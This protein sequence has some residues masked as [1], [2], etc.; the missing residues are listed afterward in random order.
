MR[1]PAGFALGA[2]LSLYAAVQAQAA[3]SPAQTEFHHAYPLTATGSVSVDN[4]AGSI[5]IL[6]WGKNTVQVDAK[7]CAPTSE[8]LNNLKIDVSNGSDS[9]RV[10]TT[11]PRLTHKTF[12]W[13]WLFDSSRVCEHDASVDY[14]IHVPNQ[15]RVT[16]STASADIDVAGPIGS[17]SVSTAS[18]DLN[19]SAIAN[20]SANAESGDMT[21]SQIGGLA[22][23]TTASGDVTCNNCSGDFSVF[24]ASGRVRLDHTRGKVQVTTTSGDIEARAFGGLAHLTSTSGDISVTLVRAAGMALSART[25]TGD[26]N[27]DVP[28]R[29]VAPVNLRTV[30]GDIEARFL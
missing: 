25:V 12:S 13:N 5:K 15:A 1:I 17:L 7:A 3:S 9:V 10:K 30:S 6:S 28:L 2:F 11:F 26:I 4:E 21:L 20:L 19:A 22:K 14:T 23:V 27:S 8:D 24:T 29:S 18:G 16:L